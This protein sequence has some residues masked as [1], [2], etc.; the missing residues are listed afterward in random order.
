MIA[1]LTP[2]AQA[3]LLLTAPLITGRNDLSAEL[4]TFGEYTKLA[5]LLR[6]RKKEPAD[7]IAADAEEIISEC[8][9]VFGRTRIE[10]LLGRGFQLSQAVDR[11][12]NRAI[13]VVSRADETYPRWLKTRLKEDAPPLLYGC[14]D[15]AL[16]E[17]GGLAV[18][19]S[20]Q[21]DD[22]LL[23]YTEGIGRMAAAASL[24]LVSGGAKGIDRAAMHGALLAGGKVAGVMADSLERAVLARDNREALMDERLVLV[25][26]Y[27]PGAG[28]NVGHAMQR[29]K[30]I[31]ALAD[32]ALV[33]TA[34][35]QK[36]G[37][38]EGAIEQLD[39]LRFV[40]VFVRAGEKCGKGNRALI[41]RGGLPW[42]EPHDGI[43]L[44]QAI[45]NAVTTVLSEPQQEVFSFTLR[46]DPPSAKGK[47]S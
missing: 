7:L 1:P 21:V 9:A 2:N 45:K 23:I 22:E 36:G 4:L 30:L 37:T 41:L 18:V 42:P 25:S 38:W 47:G 44:S 28:F 6:E 27:D 33:V 20:R 15:A 8:T 32:A 5:R 31:Y 40:P 10:A 24:T 17:T 29:N 19:G 3:I 13:W 46:E 11:W 43:E 34:D 35:F 39:R 14:G 12:N 26:P 16:L